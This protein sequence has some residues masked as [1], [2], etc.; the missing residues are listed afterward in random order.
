MCTILLCVPQ[1]LLLEGTRLLTTSTC[2]HMDIGNK[3][4]PRINP[5]YLMNSTFCKYPNVAMY[6]EHP[7]IT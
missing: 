5:L 7:Q 1:I 2:R 6:H 4:Q 3:A